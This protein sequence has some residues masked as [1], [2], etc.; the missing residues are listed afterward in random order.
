MNQ[1]FGSTLKFAVLV[2]TSLVFLGSAYNQ[3]A[4]AVWPWTSRAIVLERLDNEE[5]ILPE[6]LVV[7]GMSTRTHLTGVEA[8]TRFRVEGSDDEAHLTAHRPLFSTSWSVI[9]FQVNEAR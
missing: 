2:A 7:R 3:I 6:S 9:D 1:R 8:Q 4:L 5:I